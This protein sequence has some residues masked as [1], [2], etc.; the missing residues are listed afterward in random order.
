MTLELPSEPVIQPIAAKPGI[1]RIVR[2]WHCMLDEDHLIMIFSGFDTDGASIP[3][4]ARPIVGNPFDGDLF[5]AAVA[6]DGLYAAELCP[7]KQS[8]DW[9]LSL[10]QRMGIDEARREIMYEA[11]RIGGADVWARHTPASV[12]QARTFCSLMEIP[13]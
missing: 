1:V 6:H 9:L 12:A 4:W 7:R 10:W 5:P 3:W 13:R 11:V 2:N 8:D